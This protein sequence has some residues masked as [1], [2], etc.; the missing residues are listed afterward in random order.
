[1]AS[2]QELTSGAAGL[3]ETECLEA[4]TRATTLR[5]AEILLQQQSGLL[6][7]ALEEL[8]AAE[9]THEGLTSI[10]ERLD[11]LLRR[12]EFGLH[13][14][15]PWS[16]VVVGRPNVGKSSL[17][18]ALVGYSR[19]IVYAEPGTTRDVVTAETAFD[20]WPFRLADTAGIRDEAEDLE[21]AGIRLA[22]EQ[23]AAADLQVLL[24]DTS[25]PPHADD[26]RFLERWPDAIRIAHKCDLENVWPEDQLPADALCVSSLTGEGVNSLADVLV[27]SLL[28]EVPEA[29]TPVPITQRQVKLLAKSRQAL[30]DGDEDAFHASL[31]ECLS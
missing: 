8:Q 9:W 12:S 5:T 6:R 29:G 21:S 10:A 19:S 27:H 23:I 15:Q 4:L 18:N 25:H 2:W 31:K 3:F 28:P 30:N 16:V 11:R 14:S 22:E 26:F 1:V 24:L 7:S 17:I 13:L 20:G